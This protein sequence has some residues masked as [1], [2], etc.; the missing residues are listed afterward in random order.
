M[1]LALQNQIDRLYR[2]VLMMVAAGRIT[3]TDDKGL[4]GTAQIGISSTPE[5]LDKVPIMEMYGFHSNPPKDT[6]AVLLFG[7]GNR[8][9]PIII[10]TNQQQKRPANYQSGEVGVWNQNGDFLKFAKDNIANLIAGKSFGLDT[11]DA[12]FKGSSSVKLDTPQTT[13]TGDVKA[14]GK[15]DA[16]G[17]FWKNGQEITG[18]SGGGTVG[19]PGPQGPPGP[20]GATGPAG[21]DGNTVL[22]GTGAPLST[23][24]KD[25]DF[26]IDTSVETMWGPKTSGAWVGPPVSL[27]GPQ[28]PQGVAGAQ[29][30]T[31]PQGAQGPTGAASTVPGP[32]GPQGPKGDTGA[33][34]ATGSQGPQGVSGATGPTGPQG[35][36][37]PTGATGSQGPA[38]PTGPTGATGPQGPV[39]PAGTYQAGQGITINTGTTPPTISTATPYLPLAGGALTGNLTINGTTTHVGTTTA[40]TPATAD[41]SA[42]VATTAFVKAQGYVTGSYLPL[43]GGTL[44]G[45]LSITGANAFFF[46]QSTGDPGA[47]VNSAGFSRTRWRFAQNSG[48]QASAGSIDYGTINGAAL[49][50]VGLG[51]SI[52][53][54]NVQIYDNLTV[55]GTIVA[56][57]NIV[58]T[59]SNAGL[60]TNDRSGTGPT[61]WGFYAQGGQ[62]NVYENADG[63]RYFFTPQ[64]FCPNSDNYYYCGASGHAWYNVVSY[65]FSNASDIR[66]KTDITDL[67]E[68]LPLVEALS[69]QRFRWKHGNDRD[70]THWGFVAQDV[71]AAMT[72][73]EFGGHRIDRRGEQSIA[74]HELTA[75]LWKAVQE[76]ASQVEELKHGRII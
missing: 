38:G 53:N 8:S 52:N 58:A 31:G 42:N 73:H 18:G 45:P 68:C 43:T 62:L 71:E 9:N 39:G 10:G 51:A 60:F 46:V 29:G 35:N 14:L 63:T 21:E 17:G 30:P 13:H 36:P 24:G 22:H 44:T 41:N 66:H 2:R 23:I 4:I 64:I 11:K 70:V 3:T 69:P 57:G 5:L 65:N 19:P 12:T 7:A 20:T 72:G 50:I 61:Q 33:T 59:G 54:R 67:P 56:T 48:D 37:G 47:S 76:L 28:G 1:T 26:Y 34:G 32:T 55:G 74:Y 16:D 27:I 75:V 49:S 15:V 25:G 6:D 40:P